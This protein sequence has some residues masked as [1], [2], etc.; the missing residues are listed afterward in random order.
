[1]QATTL[2]LIFSTLHKAVFKN[3]YSRNVKVGRLSLKV[4]FE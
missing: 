4:A 1:M 3:G 2:V